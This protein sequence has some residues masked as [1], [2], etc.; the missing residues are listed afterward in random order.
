MRIQE[1]EA[2]EERKESDFSWRVLSACGLL[3][4]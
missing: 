3:G 1:E 4:N 2:E